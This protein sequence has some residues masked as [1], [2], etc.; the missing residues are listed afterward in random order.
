[1][2]GS[3]QVK[4]TFRNWIIWYLVMAMF[5]IG[6]TPKVY[7]GFSPSEVIGLS[8]D[9]RSSDLQKV[10][11]FIEMKMV[12]ERL[13]EYGLTQDEIT[14]RL[15]ELNDQQIHQLALKIDDLRVA[16]DDGLGIL[17]ALL[18]IVILVIIIVMLLGH[19][20]VIK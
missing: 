17:V 4:K 11:K 9:E 18:V 16:A 15:G 12:R 7:A 6:V 13:K 20:V 19:R 1:M 5:V 2:A 3:K 8:P 14:A 10:Q